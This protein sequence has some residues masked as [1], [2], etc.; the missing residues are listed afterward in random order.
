MTFKAFQGIE[1]NG[2]IGGKWITADGDLTVDIVMVGSC[3]FQY[4]PA[5]TLYGLMKKHCFHY[6]FIIILPM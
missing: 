5:L 1:T 3:L 6:S 4:G 2:P